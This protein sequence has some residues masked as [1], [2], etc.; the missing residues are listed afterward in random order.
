MDEISEIVA[1]NV[2]SDP[3]FVRD[4]VLE[5]PM[6]A[7]EICSSLVNIHHEFDDGRDGP[8]NRMVSL[9]HYSVK[10]YL[11]S[12]RIHNGQAA[13]YSMNPSVCHGI[14]AR[15]CLGYL[16]Q[17]QRPDS[18]SHNGGL[19]HFKLAR[20]CA[21][22]WMRHAKE[23]GDR[24][25]ETAHLAVRLMSSNSPTFVNW[26]RIY[27]PEYDA[28][29][30]TK[31]L[32]EVSTPLYYAALFDLEELV[33]MLLGQ[34]ADDNAQDGQSLQAASSFG[35]EQI[36]RLLLAHGADINAYHKKYGNALQAAC[37]G[38]HENL[39]NLLIKMGA[40][41]NAPGVFFNVRRSRSIPLYI[42]LT[43]LNSAVSGYLDIVELLLNNGADLTHVSP[44]GWT[45]LHLASYD[46]HVEIVKLLLSRGA[47]PATTDSVHGH[48]PLMAAARKGHFDVAKT[49]L[50]AQGVD[51]NAVCNKGKTALMWAAATRHHR[52]LK[53]LVQ[54]GAHAE[55]K[56]DQGG[57]AMSV[58]A[59][60]GSKSILQTLFATS[61]TEP[62]YRDN[63]G[64]TLLW[65]AAAGGNKPVVEMLMNEYH[66]DLN[67]PDNCGRQPILVAARNGHRA[68]VEHLLHASPAGTHRP[69]KSERKLL[70]LSDENSGLRLGIIC[71]ICKIQALMTD[72]YSYHCPICAG[73]DWDMCTDCK[74]GGMSCMDATHVLVKRLWRDGSWNEVE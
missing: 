65:W 43:A 59:Q 9:A 13:R 47:N 50:E 36:V 26:I 70:D 72:C 25:A 45:P 4:D 1:I 74:A 11:I 28:P 29:N 58:A 5:D 42:E 46:G 3:M 54:H 16:L 51:V 39:V 18:F 73:G 67:I 21:E 20:Y 55:H 8:T 62:G 63:Y 38:G 53:L 17:F 49:L 35:H 44:S 64:R 52:L 37:L 27:D 69:T 14:I 33:A 7:M 6:D 30:P 56:D 32:N 57:T 40:N 61:K 31:S 23:S 22:S 48:T 71:D 10:E 19:L 15:A 68:V 34:S 12:D 66:Y 2:N 41:V 60:F 24:E